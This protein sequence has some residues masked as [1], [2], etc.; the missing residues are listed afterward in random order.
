MLNVLPNPW[1]LLLVLSS[2]AASAGFAYT[3]GVSDGRREEVAKRLEMEEMARA[4]QD[5]AQQG[6]AEAI[7]EIEIKHTTVREEINR[8]ILTEVVYRDCTHTPDGL[9]LLQQALTGRPYTFAEGVVRPLDGA[10]GPVIRFDNA[11]VD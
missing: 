5:A 9:R 8:E 7:A 3:K 10:G 4:V 2:L 11:E 1:V 6:A